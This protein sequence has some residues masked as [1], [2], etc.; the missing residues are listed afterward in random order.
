LDL[1]INKYEIFNTF[2]I[3]LDE[4]NIEILVI[5]NWTPQSI[6]ILKYVPK[7]S[8]IIL[9]TPINFELDKSIIMPESK[10]TL[11][12]ISDILLEQDNIKVEVAGYTDAS[13]EETYNKVLS[14]KRADAVRKYLI[15]S[16]VRS[17]IIRSVGYGSKDLISDDPLDTINRRVEIHIKE[18]K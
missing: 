15:K 11:D 9:S 18:G 6:D 4:F 17:K 1:R 10:N 13:G 7:I 16:G 5:E 12:K 3:F 14:Q 2:D 8:T